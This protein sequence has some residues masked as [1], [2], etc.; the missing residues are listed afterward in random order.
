L[1]P[2]RRLAAASPPPRRLLVAFPSFEVPDAFRNARLYTRDVDTLFKERESDL[3]KLFA[4][5]SNKHEFLT[6]DAFERSVVR[7]CC[8]SSSAHADP[9]PSM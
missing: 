4:R 7:F 9:P 1:P 8:L 5:Y 6:F 2:R 3:R